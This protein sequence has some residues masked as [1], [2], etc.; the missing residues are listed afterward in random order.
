MCGCFYCC[1]MCAPSEVEWL[2]E[3]EGTALCPHCGIDS[4]IG[5]AS[6]FPV[7]DPEFL[8]VLHDHWFG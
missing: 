6:G 5:S 4:L 8:R 2:E 3:L 7:E 1:Q